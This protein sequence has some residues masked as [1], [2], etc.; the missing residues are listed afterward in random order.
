MLAEWESNGK[1]IASPLVAKNKRR[2]TDQSLKLAYRHVL[3]AEQMYADWHERLSA[4][5]K[6]VTGVLMLDE[7]KRSLPYIAEID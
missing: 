4:E 5:G 1:M 6:M 3:S 7:E 2:D